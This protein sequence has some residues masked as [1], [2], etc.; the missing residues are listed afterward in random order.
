MPSA[1]EVLA[2]LNN[3]RP[4]ASCEG[5]RKDIV[6][7]EKFLLLSGDHMVHNRFDCLKAFNEAVE[8]IAKLD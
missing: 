2:Y 7:G 1:E 4:V 8:M 6:M 5:C 3:E